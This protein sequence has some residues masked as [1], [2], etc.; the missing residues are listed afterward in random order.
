MHGKV[1]IAVAYKMKSEDWT[2]VDEMLSKYAQR[3]IK[4]QRGT[5]RFQSC[6]DYRETEYMIMQAATSRLD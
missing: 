3:G 4:G 5:E 1:A 2:G 6:K